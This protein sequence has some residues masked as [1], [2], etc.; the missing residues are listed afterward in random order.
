M[1]K[2]KATLFQKIIKKNSAIQIE[3][4]EGLRYSKILRMVILFSTI[5]LCSVFF[6]IHIDQRSFETKDYSVV[7]GYIWTGQ[8][9]TADFTFPVYKPQS[10]YYKDVADAKSQSLPVFIL[11]KNVESGSLKKLDN[12]IESLVKWAENKEIP[13]FSER[14][15]GFL[16]PLSTAQKQKEIEI[17]RREISSFLTEIFKTGFVD[18]S[19]DRIKYDAITV[20][21]S[22]TEIIY[23]KKSF[24]NDKGTFI[25]KAEKFISQKINN[26]TR[27]IA[28]EIVTKLL[29]PNLI[30]SEEQSEKAL[31]I[32]ENSVPRTLGIVRKGATIIEK[33]EKVTNDHIVKLQSYE[34]SRIMK[35]DTVYS[36]WIFLGSFGHAA[37]IYSI[38]ILYLIYI[39][40]KIFID[41]V[42]LLILSLILVV[43]G[44]LSWISIELPSD[45]PL[46]FLIILPAFSMLAAIVFDS[47]TAFYLTV[48]A[49]LML[50][51][52][53]GN[54]YSSGLSMIVAGTFAA[55]TVRDI[56][57]RT[58]MFK[59]IFFI[60]FG[61]LF[62]IIV[63]GL[64]HTAE[65]SMTFKRIGMA[66][67]NAA[68]SP[69]ITFGL[70]F[71][72]ERVTNLATD[73]RLQEYNNLSH[74]LLQKMSE[75]APGTYQHTLSVANLAERC[76]AAIGANELLTKV[77][78]YFHDIGKIAKPEYFA[79]NQSDFGS[80]HDL[81]SPKKSAA[82]IRDHVI[83]GI[84]LARQYKLPERIVDFIPM[85][86]GTT[87]IKHFY[88]KAVEEA[89]TAT[90]NEADFRYPGP[91]P[92]TKESAILM[93]CDSAE[94]LSRINFDTP[95]GLELAVDKNIKDRLLDG[96][97]DECNITMQELQ[98]I[99]ETCLRSLAGI[100]HQRVKYKELPTDNNDKD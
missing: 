54:D 46:E 23:L 83:S 94:A 91:K 48:T 39:R 100:S 59:S 32:A 34:A 73:L 78:T 15:L 12:M 96:Q 22:P 36:F 5:A 58:Q 51:G 79:E 31:K 26:T 85:H 45:L 75:F 95:D 50:T 72:L 69:L 60:F 40:Y 97:F 80:K 17:L 6:S 7:P 74:P 37:L 55:L 82:A 4:L 61:L 27:V 87:L 49:S 81:M 14:A 92:T 24:L 42:Q 98:I 13:S 84:E 89:K 38:L 88:A 30:F 20:K 67:I 29:F 43:V 64:V 57:N 3:K 8:T 63:F 93:I 28:S 77:G 86:H 25:D 44:L 53:R 18:L 56:K 62:P 65:M 99:K 90:V 10:Q 11:D 68:V 9:L 47:R 33:G 16:A 41:N 2:K 66:L 70:I 1:A 35:S 52:I 76:A 19:L 21:L 71:I